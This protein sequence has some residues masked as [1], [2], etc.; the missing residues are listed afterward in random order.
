MIAQRYYLILY[1]NV[2][3]LRYT[4]QIVTRRV[5]YK[6]TIIIVKKKKQLPE[7]FYRNIF[8]FTHSLNNKQKLPLIYI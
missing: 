7:V 2:Q 6:T 5:E 1:Y 8:L 3:C 4:T